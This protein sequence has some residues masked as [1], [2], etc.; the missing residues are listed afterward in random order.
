M[1]DQELREYIKEVITKESA[2]WYLVPITDQEGP[3]ADRGAASGN[4][5]GD[6][7][8]DVVGENVFNH[9]EGKKE[10]MPRLSREES[11]NKVRIVLR[12]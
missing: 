10:D 4:E 11:E 9:L 12:A 6:I 7:L 3:I 2:G 5:E 1:S 8:Q